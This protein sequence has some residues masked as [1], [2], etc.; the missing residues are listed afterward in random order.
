MVPRHL[1]SYECHTVTVAATFLKSY[2]SRAVGTFWHFRIPLMCFCKTWTFL[3]GGCK[4]PKRIR[5]GT[6]SEAMRSWEREWGGDVT[7]SGRDGPE[8]PENL[9]DHSERPGR[10]GVWGCAFAKRGRLGNARTEAKKSWWR[11]MLTG[12]TC[13]LL[14]ISKFQQISVWKTS[15]SL[16]T[17]LKV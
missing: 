5:R 7:S 10:P 2:S 3:W 9:G 6:H 17:S 8:M 12:I 4:K 14:R 11:T 13:C 15:K 16:E 1:S